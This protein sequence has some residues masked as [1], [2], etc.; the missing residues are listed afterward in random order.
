[1]PRIVQLRERAP[2]ASAGVN[3]AE[4]DGFE[5]VRPWSQAADGQKLVEE[6]RAVLAQHVVLRLFEITFLHR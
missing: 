5:E 3:T 2:G 1:M 4:P 6:L